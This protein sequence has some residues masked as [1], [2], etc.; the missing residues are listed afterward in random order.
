M[1]RVKKLSPDVDPLVVLR[2]YRAEKQAEELDPLLIDENEKKQLHA[3]YK[4]TLQRVEVMIPQIDKPSEALKSL[5]E[6]LELRA[7]VSGWKLNTK[8]ELEK[9]DGRLTKNTVTG[10]GG[11][12]LTAEEALAQTLSSMSPDDLD[13]AYARAKAIAARGTGDSVEAEAKAPVEEGD[14]QVVG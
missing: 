8:P 12:T 3:L 9:S 11:E 13:A 6:L 10:D 7:A 5:K 4:A 14:Y 1:P 2:K